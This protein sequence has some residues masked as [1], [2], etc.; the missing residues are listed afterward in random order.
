MAEKLPSGKYRYKLYTGMKDGKRHYMSFVAETASKA[1]EEAERWKTL[2]LSSGSN[3]SLLEASRAFL[4]DRK[5]TL[6]PSTYNDYANRIEYLQ[7]F[8]PDL[9]KKRLSAVTT[10][11]LQ[12]LVNR[13]SAKPKKTGGVI[14][15]KTVMAYYSL[16]DTVLKYHGVKIDNV[17]LPQRKPPEL[18]IPEDET[19]TRLLQVIKGT[20]LE[21]PVL[22]AALGPMRR[23]E[24]CALT[25]NDIDGNI[26][27]VSKSMV[28]TNER[29]WQ[30]K[31]PKTSAGFRDIEYPAYVTDLIRE[32]GYIVNCNPD[33]LSKH[34]VRVLSRHGFDHFRFHD[35][36]HYAA[37]FLLALGIPPLYVMERGGWQSQHSMR[38]YTHALDKQKAEFAS[39]ANSA[40]EK[41]MG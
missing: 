2:N 17:H 16:L 39:L 22:L 30:I 20:N 37:S 35:L 33:T 27:H 4:R 34:F 6:S 26:V 3:Q 11:D 40:F 18:V 12:A 5:N 14:S 41:I 8:A 29:D 19:V 25:L 28:L 38:R 10:R 31:Y 21:I 1:R 36:R 24:I 32:K 15:P 9:F 23:G 13:L 7:D